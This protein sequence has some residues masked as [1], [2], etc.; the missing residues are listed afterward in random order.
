MRLLVIDDEET[1]RL[2]IKRA[3][4]A[5]GVTSLDCI[6]IGKVEELDGLL[7]SSLPFSVVL[8]DVHFGSTRGPTLIPTLKSHSPKAYI[9]CIST[10]ELQEDISECYQ[11]KADA[12][13]VK[14]ATLSADILKA[15]KFAKASNEAL[16]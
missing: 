5:L 6:E 11:Q 15:V 4:S 9:I 14:G 10:S 2:L 3:L 13:V 7:A 16:S 1:H 8:L 12:Y